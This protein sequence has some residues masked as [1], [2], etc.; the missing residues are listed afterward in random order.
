M[1]SPPPWTK[2]QRSLHNILE[3][4]FASRFLS[5][6]GAQSQDVATWPRA[7]SLPPHPS[8]VPHLLMLC[9][10]PSPS[11]IAQRCAEAGWCL[12]GRAGP[13]S[14]KPGEGC[15]SGDRAQPPASRTHHLW[16]VWGC[17]EC[18]PWGTSCLGSR[19]MPPSQ[20]TAS[21]C[22]QLPTPH[23]PVLRTHTGPPWGGSIYHRADM[24]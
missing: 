11:Q 9:P 3:E 22:G 20:C 1:W 21:Q 12:P 23:H 4:W 2:G 13:E 16:W 24:S 10:L 15:G 5:L 14:W 17:L 19:L 8:S 7:C 6:L 18:W